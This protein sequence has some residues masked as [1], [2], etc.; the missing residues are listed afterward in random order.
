MGGLPARQQAV[1]HSALTSAGPNRRA[2]RPSP[3]ATM[4]MTPTTDPA[5]PGRAATSRTRAVQVARHGQRHGKTEDQRVGD[6]EGQEV[7][8]GA[9]DRQR[10]RPFAGDESREPDDRHGDDRDPDRQRSAASSHV[11][12][13]R[14]GATARGPSH[15]PTTVPIGMPRRRDAG[16]A[17][18]A[19]PPAE[20]CDQARGRGTRHGPGEASIGRNPHRRNLRDQRCATT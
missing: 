17:A 18:E 9:G 3:T 11:A 1:P 14:P 13:A 4:A 6:D 8:A 16:E 2:P 5:E 19:E 7:D 10:A 15:Q 12:T 20:R